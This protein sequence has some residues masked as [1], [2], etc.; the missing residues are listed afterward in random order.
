MYRSFEQDVQRFPF[1]FFFF[2]LFFWFVWEWN[3]QRFLSGQGATKV[4]RRA[5][6]RF[7][8]LTLSVT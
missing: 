2:F 8:L 6:L 4:R 3:V 7:S 1:F 5:E